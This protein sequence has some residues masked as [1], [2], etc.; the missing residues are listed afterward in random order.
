MGSEPVYFVVPGLAGWF[1][2]VH[3]YLQSTI[4]FAQCSD[5]ATPDRLIYQHGLAH[6]IVNEID[7]R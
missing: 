7:F 5:R 1:S 2:L 4:G 6:F 3:K